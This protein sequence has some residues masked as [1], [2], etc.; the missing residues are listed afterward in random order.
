[1]LP[2][3]PGSPYAPPPRPAGRLGVGLA[4]AASVLW[5]CSGNTDGP[6]IGGVAS[7]GAATASAY[8]E[9][10]PADEPLAIGLTFSSNFFDELPTEPSDGHQCFDRNGDG[11]LARPDECNAWHEWAIPLPGEV[12]TRA[13]IPFKWSLLNWNPMGHIPPGIYDVPHFDIHF[14]IDP[15]EDV[16]AIRPGAC[17]PEFVDCGQFVV[18]TR[19]LPPN[20]QAPDYQDVQAVAPAMG[21]HLIDVTSS[22]FQGEP[23]T[24]TWIYGIYD[25]RVTYYEEMVTRAFLLDRPSECFDIKSPPAVGLAGYYPTQSCLRY[26]ADTGA[27]TVSMEGFVY[28]EASPPDPIPTATAGEGG[29]G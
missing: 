2:V 13:D 22:E 29:E 18:A 24:R 8:A 11:M 21:N 1:M 17:G 23:F 12:A 28:R 5:A 9:F 4:L 19:P 20:Y 3:C 15:I 14:Y 7:I 10:G 6:A 25:G 26:H 27:Y 16:F